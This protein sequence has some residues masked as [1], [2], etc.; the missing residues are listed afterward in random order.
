MFQFSIFKKNLRGFTLIEA[1]ALLFFFAVIT[2][3]FFQAYA[4]GT[5]MIIE[6]KKRLGAT[7]LANQK[8]EIIRSLDYDNVGTTTGIPSGDISEYENIGVNGVQYRVYTFV[9]YADDAFDGKKEGN[10]N[11][12]IPNDYKRVRL[13]VSWGSMGTDQTISTFANVSPNGVETAAG[14]GVLSINILD[15]TGSGVA[16]ATVHI[17]NAT[18]GVNIT[19]NTDSTGN[20]TLPGT[21]A[22]TYQL[23]VSKSGYYGTMTY[24]PAPPSVFVPIDEHAS[25]VDSVLNQKSMVMDQ[26]ADIAIHSKDPF[27]TDVPN[28]DFQM[29]GGKILGTDPTTGNNV[30]EYNQALST[31]ASGI[32]DISDQSYGQYTLSESDTRY[33]LYK[34]NPGGVTNNIFDALPAQTTSVDMILLDTEIGSVKIVVTSA[35]DSSPVAGA[36]A[37]L[38]NT[39]LGYD[40]TAT[41]DQYGFVYFPTA[42]PELAAGTYDLGVSAAGFSNN[43]STVSV[44]GGLVTKEVGLNP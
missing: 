34:L 33:Q 5:R 11:D 1:L 42:L 44:S 4:T 27:G 20:I 23:T 9:Q 25:V 39:G 19:T 14:G 10:P 30:Y 35:A 29:I 6:S 26:Y 18:A 7:A 40:A 38:T 15:T 12:A 3:T 13:S 43:D 32:K 31:N 16:G 37:H 41:T 36:T 21:P 8:M 28:I 24:P 2:V 17:V 22:G